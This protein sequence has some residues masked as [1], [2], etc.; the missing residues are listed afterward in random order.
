[1]RHQVSRSLR[2][3]GHADK[4]VGAY[5]YEVRHHSGICWVGAAPCLR[6][7]WGW[8]LCGSALALMQPCARHNVDCCPAC[9]RAVFAPAVLTS[10][11]VYTDPPLKQRFDNESNVMILSVGFGHVLDRASGTSAEDRAGWSGWLQARGDRALT[12]R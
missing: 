2:D 4:W 10:A 1:M 11:Q 7:W 12:E 5:A 8:P 3:N 9:P 6:L